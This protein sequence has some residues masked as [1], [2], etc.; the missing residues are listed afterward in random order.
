MPFEA[1]SLLKLEKIL[2]FSFKACSRSRSFT[3]FLA[4]VTMKEDWT[5]GY[6]QSEAAGHRQGLNEWHRL[7]RDA[8]KPVSARQGE[9]SEKQKARLPPREEK[10]Q[11]PYHSKTAFFF[12]SQ[13]KFKAEQSFS[14]G[15]SVGSA[16]DREAR[17]WVKPQERSNK[18]WAERECLSNPGLDS[19]YMYI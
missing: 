4:K 8:K 12:W 13:L 18:S 6:Q 19:Q 14:K 5:E 16:I 11:E 1:G 3:C 7:H 10:N 9:D 2:A 15:L 17:G